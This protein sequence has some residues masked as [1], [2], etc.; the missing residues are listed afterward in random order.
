MSVYYMTRRT[1]SKTV[2]IKLAHLDIAQCRNLTDVTLKRVSRCE[3]LDT[4]KVEFDR[5]TDEGVLHLHRH[6]HASSCGFHECTVT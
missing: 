1:I 6:V 4:I 3:R 5:I 2:G